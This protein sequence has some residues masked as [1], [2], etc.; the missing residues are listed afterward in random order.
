MVWAEHV[1]KLASCITFHCCTIAMYRL[2]WSIWIMPTKLCRIKWRCSSLNVSGTSC[3]NSSSWSTFGP[4]R[5]WSWCRFRSFSEPKVFDSMKCSSSSKGY[6]YCNWLITW[7]MMLTSNLYKW[8]WGRTAATAAS[9]S[10]L[11]TSRRPRT[12]SSREPMP[13]SVSWRPTR[14]FLLTLHYILVKL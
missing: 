1:P 7:I 9:A 8:Q 10:G 6:T 5:E 3:W 13:S 2:N 4:E 14:Q 11:S 12:C